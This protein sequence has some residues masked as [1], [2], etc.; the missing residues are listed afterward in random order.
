MVKEIFICSKEDVKIGIANN[1]F[2]EG[3]PTLT[4]TILPPDVNNN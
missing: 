2:F 1:R 4:T 3:D